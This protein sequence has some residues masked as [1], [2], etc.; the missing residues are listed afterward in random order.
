MLPWPTIMVIGAMNCAQLKEFFEKI[1]GLCEMNGIVSAP[2][3]L[4]TPRAVAVSDDTLSVELED[5]RT[6]SVPIGWYPRLAYGTLTERNNFQIAG[7]GYGIHWP[8]LDEDI[9]V[10]GLLAGKKSAETQ[11]HLPVGCNIALQPE[12]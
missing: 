11:P 2:P 6:I 10:V 5:G 9:G 8:D 7:A 12:V 3:A 1:W 4:I